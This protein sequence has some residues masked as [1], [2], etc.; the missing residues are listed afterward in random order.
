MITDSNHENTQIFTFDDSEIEEARSY[1]RAMS[2]SD[3]FLRNGSYII[4]YESIMKSASMLEIEMKSILNIALL[5]LGLIT[6]F[7]IAT[8]FVFSTK[9]RFYEI[10]V[11]RAIGASRTDICIQFVIE[12]IVYSLLSWVV[13]YLIAVIIC[14]LLQSVF[15]NYLYMYLQFVI[16]K[17]IIFSSLGIAFVEGVICSCIPA[18]LAARV[19]PTEALRFD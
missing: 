13:S 3:S 16:N 19:R 1:F 18:T 6:V 10:G 11:R 2:E 8:I 12:G 15:S 4:S 14:N 5:A 17:K 9:E 7:T